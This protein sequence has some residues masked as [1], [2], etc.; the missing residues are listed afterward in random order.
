MFTFTTCERFLDPQQDRTPQHYT[1][2]SLLQCA[3]SNVSLCNDFF[4]NRVVEIAHIADYI[5]IVGLLADAIVHSNYKFFNIFTLMAGAAMQ[6]ANCSIWASASN[7]RTI[8]GI[9]TFRLLDDL[10]YL[11]SYSCPNMHTTHCLSDSVPNW[12]YTLC[13]VNNMCFHYLLPSQTVCHQSN[14][15]P[16]DPGWHWGPGKGESPG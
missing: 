3:F 7:W 16:G 13:I 4:S 1:V 15:R 5:Y 8:E 14:P 6:G 12:I 10:L 2:I 11:L 9:Q